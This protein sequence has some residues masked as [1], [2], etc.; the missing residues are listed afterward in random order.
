MTYPFVSIARSCPD[1][2]SRAQA[3]VDYFSDNW[4]LRTSDEITAYIERLGN[5][6]AHKAIPKAPFQWRFIV[7]RNEAVH[8]MALGDGYI[9]VTDGIITALDNESEVAAVLAHEMSHQIA[10]HLCKLPESGFFSSSSESQGKNMIK[11]G[12]FTQIYDL[13]KEIEADKAAVEI[14]K[15]TGYDPFA[16]LNVLKNKAIGKLNDQQNQR[17]SVLNQ[18]L[19]ADYFPWGKKSQLGDSFER[20]RGT[21]R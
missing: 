21:A 7:V 18:K 11:H 6:I 10:G 12:L 14:L 3:S 8:A 20:V 4:P 13:D 2:I 17:I 1:E 9:L 15:M 19:H 16:M 5:M